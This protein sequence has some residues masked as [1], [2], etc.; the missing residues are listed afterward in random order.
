[1]IYLHKIYGLKLKDDDKIRYIGLTKQSLSRRMIGH[2]SHAKDRK[3]KVS[4]WLNKYKD[5]VEII[6]IE[7]NI[8]TREECCKKER[9][10]IKLFKSFGANLLNH[11]DGGEIGNYKIGHKKSQEWKD[12]ASKRMIGNKITLGRKMTPSQKSKLIER[13]EKSKIK[14]KVIYNDSEY[15]FNGLQELA[16]FFSIS[17]SGAH[18]W[19]RFGKKNIIIEKI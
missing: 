6:L 10:Y 4:N 15:Y 11:T 18:K 9:E 2:F 13:S 1:M 3:Y 12:Q 19:V 14:T 8:P 17:L 5:N 16:D 7:D